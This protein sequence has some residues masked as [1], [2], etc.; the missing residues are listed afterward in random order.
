[1]RE[2]KITDPNK[3]PTWRVLRKK[4][5]GNNLRDGEREARDE[6]GR[7]R[8]TAVRRLV[9]ALGGLQFL[10]KGQQASE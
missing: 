6:R 9:M 4:N 7:E 3:T 5:T 8:R 10:T 1:M 2:S